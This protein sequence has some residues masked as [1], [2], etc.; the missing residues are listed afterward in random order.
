MIGDGRDQGVRSPV[1]VM[2]AFQDDAFVA[3]NRS[4]VLFILITRI[5][6]KARVT[7]IG[8]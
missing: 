2:V 7:S 4:S 3:S 8:T 5:Y 1:S 6:G